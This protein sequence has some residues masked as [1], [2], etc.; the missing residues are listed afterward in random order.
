MPAGS[1]PRA[2]PPIYDRHQFVVIALVLVALTAYFNWGHLLPVP[3]AFG[4]VDRR[5]G[6]VTYNEWMW[7]SV[8]VTGFYLVFGV[9]GRF[10]FSTA[11]FVGLGAYLSHYL[12]SSGNNWSVGFVASIVVAS[13]VGFGFAL[14]VRKAH[15]FYFAVATLGLAELMLIVFRQ[16]DVLVGRPGGEIRSVRD[17]TIFGLEIDTRYRHFYVWLVALAIVLVIAALIERSPLRRTAIAARDNPTVSE[18]V[19]VD[20][21]W[22]GIVLF[23]LGCAIA[24]AAGS[25]F[26]HTRALGTPETFGLELGIGIF[27]VLILGGLHSMFG[28]VI[29][30][31]FY[32][33]VPLYLEQWERWTQVIWGLVLVA[34]M[35]LFPE[36][37]VGVWHRI[38]GTSSPGDT[39]R[40]LLDRIASR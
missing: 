9:A 40:S 14:V 8:I 37:L 35:I 11:S 33:Y 15:H 25:L 19:G 10:A 29:G 24:A 38:V 17:M 20:V 28:A 5:S 6:Q 34:V 32:V 2:R 1:E 26:V 4:E 31:W 21:H 23:T 3:G 39:R 30:A 7:L 18:T 16:W 13:V 12:T 27:V 36:G 22:P